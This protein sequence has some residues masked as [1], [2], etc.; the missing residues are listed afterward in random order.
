MR[1]CAHYDA[2]D[3]FH[4]IIHRDSRRECNCVFY[5]CTFGYS[6]SANSITLPF[7]IS[8]KNTHGNTDSRTDSRTDA[9]ENSTCTGSDKYNFRSGYG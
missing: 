4:A 8:H 1:A 2:F 6:A 9:G 3:N 5:A 7:S